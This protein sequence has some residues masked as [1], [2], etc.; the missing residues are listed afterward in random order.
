MWVGVHTPPAR[1]ESLPLDSVP[2]TI[3][4]ARA[5]TS[6]DMH[7]KPGMSRAV[8]PH[9]GY[10]ASMVGPSGAGAEVCVH[11]AF[12]CG[13]KSLSPTIHAF[14]PTPCQPGWALQLILRARVSLPD[15]LVEKPRT[16][17]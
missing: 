17:A 3:L 13:Y 12:G 1:P 10:S 16:P 14:A 8:A 5:A 6:R 2:W 7:R 11:L 15:F 4:R 9:P